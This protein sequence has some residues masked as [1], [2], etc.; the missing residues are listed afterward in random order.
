MR[1]EQ[2]ARKRWTPRD[3]KAP[4]PHLLPIPVLKTT[5][6]SVY[7]PQACL[8]SLFQGVL[9]NRQGLIKVKEQGMEFHPK[10]WKT[11]DSYLAKPHKLS[12]RGGSHI[13]WVLTRSPGIVFYSFCFC[14][15]FRDE[16]RAGIISKLHQL[17]YNFY[18][19][20]II[21][22]FIIIHFIY[23]C[24]ATCFSRSFFSCSSS[25]IL[26]IVQEVDGIEIISNSQLWNGLRRTKRGFP[27]TVS[28]SKVSGTCL[29]LNYLFT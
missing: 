1:L 21:V 13:Y 18:L 24:S 26:K 14:S 17:W 5:I 4:L 19:R 8:T 11:L 27:K 20:D 12:T 15:C 23:L 25:L 7:W 22:F 28:L 10:C 9:Q 2:D 16:L 29:I 3:T 6:L